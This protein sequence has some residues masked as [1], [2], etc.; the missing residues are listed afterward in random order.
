MADPGHWHD[1]DAKA[2]VAAA[3]KAVALKRQHIYQRIAEFANLLTPVGLIATD[4]A[5]QSGWLRV[6]HDE[7]KVRSSVAATD[8]TDA[9]RQ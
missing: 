6:L 9:E 4:G 7:I 8:Q 1:T 2:A 3:A 5:I